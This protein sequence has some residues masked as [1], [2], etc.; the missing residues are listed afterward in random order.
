M[1]LRHAGPPALIDWTPVLS[2]GG[3]TTGITYSV[4]TGKY[5]TIGRKVEAFFDFTLSSKGLLTGALTLSVPVTAT[6]G[7]PLGLIQIAFYTGMAS[8]NGMMAGYV[9]GAAAT[10]AVATATAMGGMNNA[11]LTDTSRL[12]GRLLYRMP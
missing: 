2:I 9:I 10:F 11:H 7:S 12:V 4:Q 8:V 3:A 1:S 6:T 5:Q